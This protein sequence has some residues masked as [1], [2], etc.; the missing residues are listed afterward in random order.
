M[1][2]QKEQYFKRGVINMTNETESAILS[3]NQCAEYLKISRGSAYNACL[4]GEIPHIKIGRRILIPRV[5]LQKLLSEAGNSKP[6]S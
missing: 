5:A 2:Y 3:V 6:I 1:Q 4:T